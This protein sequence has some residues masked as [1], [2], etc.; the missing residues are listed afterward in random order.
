MSGS[1]SQ[2][3]IH[4]LVCV[5]ACKA[6]INQRYY[7]GWGVPKEVEDA[8]QSSLREAGRRWRQQPEGRSEGRRNGRTHKE[9]WAEKTL[10]DGGLDDR[11]AKRDRSKEDLDLRGGMEISER[12]TLWAQ[13]RKR[14]TSEANKKDPV[15]E[16]LAS[17]RAGNVCA[18]KTVY[19]VDFARGS[20]LTDESANTICHHNLE[21]KRHVFSK[22]KLFANAIKTDWMMKMN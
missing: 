18:K 8:L 22:L 4:V 17:E 10:R 16:W 2:L 12:W 7:T 11:V 15:P 6:L 9:H 21:D 3:P 19:T 20:H 13:S 14:G 1:G 5:H